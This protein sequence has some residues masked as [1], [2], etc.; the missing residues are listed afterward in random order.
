MGRDFVPGTRS[1]C[2]RKARPNLQLV[3]QRPDQ[4]RP[5][6]ARNSTRTL[7]T[8]TTIPGLVSLAN[9]LTLVPATTTW[10]LVLI[11]SATQTLRDAQQ[12]LTRG[13]DLRIVKVLLS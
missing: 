11:C 2:G 3:R 13:R 7:R 1:Q 12:D 10:D 5:W 8:T 6:M 4:L 9:V